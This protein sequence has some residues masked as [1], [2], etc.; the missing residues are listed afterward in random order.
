MTNKKP[1]PTRPKLHSRPQ[2]TLARSS[3]GTIQINYTIPWNEVQNKKEEALKHLITSLEVPGFRKGKAPADVAQKHIKTQDLYNH[4]LQDLLP[5]IYAD[6]IEKHKLQPILA[7]RFELISIEDGKDWQTRAIT[8][9]LPTVNLGDYK[10][11]VQTAAAS[12]KIWIPGQTD[13]QK[14]GETKE[15]T[16]EEKEEKVLATLL[17]NAKIQVPRLLL[18]EEVNHKLAKLLEQT[19]RLGLTIEQYLASTGKTVEQIKNEFTTQAAEAITLELA[20][21]KVAEEEKVTVDEQEVDNIIQASGSQETKQA[22]AQ[23]SQRRLIKAVLKRR[24][25]LDRLTTLV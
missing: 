25:A 1:E 16:R 9:E 3:D 20:L 15:Q 8:C 2:S 10:K 6:S 5:E 21:N 13:K 18:E 19:Q 14:N 4:L 7:P 12:K 22:L 24:K 23:D 11:A 17:E